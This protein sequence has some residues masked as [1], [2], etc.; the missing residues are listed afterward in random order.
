MPIRLGIIGLSADPQAWATKAHVGPRKSPALSEKYSVTAV[1]TS[2]PE[3]AE[4]AAKSH[5]VAKEKAYS[6]PEA[7]A[8]DS[9]VDMVVVSVKV[10]TN[11]YF[12]MPRGIWDL[13]RDMLL[14]SNNRYR[15]TSNCPF[16]PWKQRKTSSLNSPWATVLQRP[17][18]WLLWPRSTA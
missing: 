11:F 17:K 9:A 10:R 1:A 18:N 3:S 4:A 12:H 5:D 8:M 7:I 13:S 16:L 2:K 15:F 6:S 14:V